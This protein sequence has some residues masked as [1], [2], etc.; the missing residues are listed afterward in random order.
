MEQAIQEQLVQT[1]LH[2]WH[3]NL[4]KITYCLSLLSE[5]QVWQQSNPV[6]NSIGNLIVHLCGNISQYILAT[7][8]GQVYQR[9]RDAEFQQQQNMPKATLLQQLNNVLLEAEKITQSC[10]TDKWLQ[11]YAVQIYHMSGVAIL[12]HVTE[13]LSYHTGQIAFITKQI[14]GTDLGFYAALK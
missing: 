7:L 9:N 2:Y 5:E 12:I 3:E 11:L 10:I 8:G 13:H 1:C 14:T 4:H 6:T